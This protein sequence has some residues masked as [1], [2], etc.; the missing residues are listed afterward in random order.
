M[1]S[2]SRNLKRFFV[3]AGVTFLLAACGSSGC[4]LFARLFPGGLPADTKVTIET[5]VSG[6]AM[7]VDLAFAPDGRAFYTEK[8]TG[9]IRVIKNGVLLSQPF[10]SVPVN[11]ASE[12]GLLGID[13]HPNFAV[14]G[15]VYVYYTRSSTGANTTTSANVLEHRVV[16]FVANGDVAAG[17]EVIMMTLPAAGPGNHNGGIIRFGIDGKLYISIGDLGVPAN[18]QSTSVLPGKILRINDD[19]S[20]PADNPFGAA[21]SIYAVG[22]RNVF[23]LGFDADGRLFAHDNGPGNHDELNLI[24]AGGNYGWP[25]VEG[26][27]DDGVGDPAG[28]SVFAAA[29]ANYHDP[30]TDKTDGSVGATGVD[31]ARVGAYGGNV[32]GQVFFGQ[33][34]L[35]RIIR[36]VRDAAG[37]SIVEQNVFATNLDGGVNGLRFGPDGTLWVTTDTR[38]V[39][40][41]STP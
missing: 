12:R 31:V 2:K 34:G 21:S 28:E 19:G 27:A 9:Q 26:R 35:S 15:F 20:I 22:L 33:F 6:A 17:S 5:V 16:R 10:A 13:L 30:L 1:I 23:G 8:A 40:L 7:P 37:T 14:N 24:V 29:T 39:R 25:S 4:Q 3:S 18:S 32:T 36:G 38:V 11:S 41:P